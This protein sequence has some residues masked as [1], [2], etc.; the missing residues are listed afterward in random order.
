MPGTP[1]HI[2]AAVAQA[3]AEAPGDRFA[4]AGAFATALERRRP[5]TLADRVGH[6]ARP[7]LVAAIL[8]IAVTGW[9]L[10]KVRITGIPGAVDPA[11]IAVLPFVDRGVD[12]ALRPVAEGLT[13]DLV[14]ALSAVSALHV[15]SMSQVTA[16]QHG[17][18]T[19]DSIARALRLTSYVEGSV[20]GTLDLPRVDVRLVDAATG[21]VLEPWS[22][23]AP[24]GEL[25]HVRDSMVGDITRHLRLALGRAIALR[26]GRNEATSEEAWELVR[27]S[28]ELRDYARGFGVGGDPTATRRAFDQADSL[29]ARAGALDP[30]WVEPL[31]IRGW[32]AWSR[33]IAA[34]PQPNTGESWNAWAA[35]VRAGLGDANQALRLRPGDPRALEQRGFLRYQLADALGAEVGSDSLLPQAERDLR[36]AV[37]DD[38]TLARAWYALSDVL[39]ARGAKA[40][41]EAAARQAYEA[42]AYLAEANFVV[43]RLFGATLER[44]EFADAGRWCAEGRRRFPDDPNFLECRLTLLGWSGSGPSDLAEATREVARLDTVGIL[45]EGRPARRL[46]LAMVVARSGY[47]DSA[48]ALLTATARA[49]PHADVGLF[50]AEVR[51]LVGQPDTALVV[52][53]ALLRQ[54][55]D[56]RSYVGTHYWFRGLRN[57]A[58]FEALVA[59]PHS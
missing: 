52:L 26:R 50:V 3:L 45:G 33:A 40:E 27:R 19:P 23:R 58:R 48:L 29:A 42:D 32:I 12:G 21:Q 11:R 43:T 10:W 41:A 22:Q 54:H 7:A 57:D 28:A 31:L 1:P 6:L 18:L 38:P 25:L 9:W 8:V 2:I 44:A 13:E 14:Q 37:T 55:P 56:W 15:A 47:P 46:L 24:R 17:G 20:S 30:G 53:S 36:S 39:Q 59:P 4:T 35:L 49:F 51:L 5:P 16:M 34:A